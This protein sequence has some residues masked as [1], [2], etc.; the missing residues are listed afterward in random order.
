MESMVSAAT[1]FAE[2]LHRRSNQYILVL[3]SSQTFRSDSN[4]LTLSHSD[5]YVTMP[6]PNEQQSRP[7]AARP[8]TDAARDA[9]P[10]RSEW[11]TRASA[12]ALARS[13]TGASDRLGIPTMA[14]RAAW[15]AM[16]ASTI[17]EIAEAAEHERGTPWPQPLASDYARY[18]RDGNRTAYESA[19]AAR[20]ERLTRA[21]VMAAHT[22]EQGRLDE[23]A[24][25]IVLL[26]EQ[27]SW[28]W[29]AHDDTFARHGH[30]IP[31]AASPYVDLGAGEVIAQ[32]AWADHVL[33]SALQARVPGLRERIRHEAELR[34]FTPFVERDD[35]WWLGL[36]RTPI[37]WTPWIAGNLVTAAIIL[38]DDPQHRA[39]I[40]ARA[41]E[42][43][44][45]FAASLPADGAIDEGV[46]YWWNGAGRMLECLELLAR[47]TGGE[48]DASGLPILREV[49][50]FPMRM[51]L[52]GPWYVNLADGPARSTGG[53][54]WH[55]PFR[56]GHITADEPVVAHARAQ[57]IPATSVASVSSGLGRV[58]HAL[59]DRDWVDAMPVSPP[60]PGRV[61]LPSVQVLLTR[62]HPGDPRGLALAIKGGH[63][64]ESHN[65][66]DLGSYI[67]ALD[68]VPLIV[69][70]GQPTYT[71][72]TFGPDRYGIRA[73]Q[74]GWH[75]T[76][77]PFGLEQGEGRAFH[78]ELVDVPLFADAV[79]T[80][81]FDLAAAYP[82][83]PSTSS[84]T[85]TRSGTDAAAP[86]PSTGS[87][88]GWRRTATLDRDA[89]RVTISD[90]WRLN[91]VENAQPTCIQL[92][93]A[94][95]VAVHG[96]RVVVRHQDAASGLVIEWHDRNVQT[97]LEEWP[98]DDPLLIASWGGRLTR[99]ALIAPQADR[100]ELTVTIGAER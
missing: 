2:A 12:A 38:C 82:L 31:T 1:G 84:G 52:G 69:D 44:D 62:E 94:G 67:V 71:A 95:D 88:T 32:L 19:V 50:R 40:V 10:L 77:A 25:G 76:A 66:K 78:V 27:S 23:A 93:L 41:I 37:N 46:A 96:T 17:T 33:G 15:R 75:N 60:L 45:R 68:G 47:A 11:G 98:L 72:Q 14:D 4:T 30:V 51:H 43:L 59:A 29:A 99:L 22:A 48:L 85:D 55:V 18:F 97:S 86:G 65:H 42:A 79:D 64:A 16:D 80:L 3:E 89:R 39:R 28:S 58:L 83:G 35:W 6:T 73:M 70:A 5:G 90:A 26:C 7:L 87:G 13:L 100:G 9:G 74:S 81:T 57:R 61:W 49:L 21:V 54:P 34:V 63:N 53:Q 92:I 24:D 91:P 20:Q 56:W 36:D 8:F